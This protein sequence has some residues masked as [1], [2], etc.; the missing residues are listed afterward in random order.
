MF[1]WNYYRLFSDNLCLMTL[2]DNEDSLLR[3]A[4]VR[5]I[6]SRYYYSAYHFSSEYLRLEHNLP[7]L[8]YERYLI[9]NKSP[10]SRGEAQE[11]KRRALAEES[12]S[13]LEQ[14]LKKSM[15]T[16]IQNALFD[17]VNDKCGNAYSNL[18]SYRV[19]ADYNQTPTFPNN[20]AILAFAELKKLITELK[21]EGYGK[22]E[23]LLS[24]LP[25]ALKIA[26]PGDA[27]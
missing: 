1:D 24:S 25:A 5:S 7:V 12:E 26:V 14:K 16:I 9:L 21:E 19:E 22:A 10:S 17:K 8:L 13:A 2:G 18:K 15:H 4:R 27:S 3:E 11:F 23:T 6:V 20:K